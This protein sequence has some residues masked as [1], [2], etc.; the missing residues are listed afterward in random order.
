[1]DT[2]TWFLLA[3]MSF[4]CGFFTTHVAKL[5][6]YEPIGWFFAGFFFWIIGLIAVIG[7][8][9]KQRVVLSKKDEEWICMICNYGRRGRGLC[10]ICGNEPKFITLP[11]PSHSAAR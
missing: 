2:S 1:M 7:V 9:E 5:K 6:G 4:S 8:P 3:V 10:G 11:K